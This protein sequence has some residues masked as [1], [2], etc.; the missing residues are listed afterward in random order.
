MK[1][2]PANRPRPSRKIRSILTRLPLALALLI[3][4]LMG[5]SEPPEPAQPAENPAVLLEG[6]RA[7]LEKAKQTEQLILDADEKRRKEMGEQGL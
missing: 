2:V 6:Q 5:C 1:T 3:A 4:P 7:T